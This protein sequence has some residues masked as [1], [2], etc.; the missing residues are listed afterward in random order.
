M[1]LQ[2]K[3]LIESVIFVPVSF[4]SNW[5]KKDTFLFGVF[6]RICNRGKAYRKK[7]PFTSTTRPRKFIGVFFSKRFG[8]KH[9]TNSQMFE[10]EVIGYREVP[11]ETF[12]PGDFRPVRPS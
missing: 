1:L 6:P 11:P 8:Q 7:T 9:K 3:R 5:T 2:T 10:V 12:P 4:F